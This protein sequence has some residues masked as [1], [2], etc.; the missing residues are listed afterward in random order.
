[1][2][3]VC[4]VILTSRPCLYV[5]HEWSNVGDV[6]ASNPPRTPEYKKGSLASTVSLALITLEL[7]VVQQTVLDELSCGA[8][9]ALSGES[10]PFDIRCFWCHMFCLKVEMSL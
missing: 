9:E 8:V 5:G 10:L 2:K 7:A 6:G 3:F 4:C 1:M